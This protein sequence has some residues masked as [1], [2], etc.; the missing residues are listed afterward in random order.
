MDPTSKLLVKKPEPVSCSQHFPVI[1]RAEE[2]WV[3]LPMLKAVPAPATGHHGL[4]SEDAFTDFSVTNI[5]T[6]TELEDFHHLLSFPGY[7][8]SKLS[9]ILF[10]DCMRTGTCTAG[11]TTR[12]G[13]PQMYCGAAGLDIPELSK[14]TR[15]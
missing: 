10:G 13:G 1:I 6:Q 4:N 15:E 11:Q 14:D 12:G 3:E 7:R 2:A 8:E 9:E 5:Y